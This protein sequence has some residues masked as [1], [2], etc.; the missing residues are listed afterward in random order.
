MFLKSQDQ[1]KCVVLNG[2]NPYHFA[3]N[4]ILMMSKPDIILNVAMVAPTTQAV[5]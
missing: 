3:I 5:Q 2:V 1:V 4:A